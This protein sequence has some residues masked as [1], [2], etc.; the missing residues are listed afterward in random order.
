MCPV[1]VA[2]LCGIRFLGTLV[3]LGH[4]LL[5]TLERLPD[6]RKT[7]AELTGD[8]GRLDTSIHRSADGI[9]LALAECWSPPVWRLTGSITFSFDFAGAGSRALRTAGAVTRLRRCIS[10]V[11]ASC[12]RLRSLSGRPVSAAGRLAGSTVLAM[13]G[14]GARR[15]DPSSRAPANR[16]GS[17]S[18]GGCRLAIGATIATIRSLGKPL[19]E[20]TKNVTSCQ[21]HDGEDQTDDQIVTKRCGKA[22]EWKDQK[23]LRRRPITQCR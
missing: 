15:I 13:V 8:H 18:V 4:W 5:H 10:T 6:G 12:S 2:A 22:E 7:D 20:V 21:R 11:S 17:G 19:E 23:R 16:S 14:G 9:H 3:S 1:Q